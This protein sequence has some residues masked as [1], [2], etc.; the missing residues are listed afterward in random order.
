VIGFNLVPYI[1]GPFVV[2]ALFLLAASAAPWP[3]RIVAAIAA[4]MAA[5]LTIGAV[6]AVILVFDLRAPDRWAWVADAAD[7][8][9]RWLNVTTG[10]DDSTDWLRRTI[11]GE[12]AALDVFDGRADHEAALQRA[13]RRFPPDD[14]SVA[15]PRTIGGGRSSEQVD[16]AFLLMSAHEAHGPDRDDL[17]EA[18]A[19][20]LRPGGRLILVE[21]LRDLPN[22]LAF[23]PGAWHF[24]PRATW[25]ETAGRAGLRPVTEVGL[26]PFVRGFVFAT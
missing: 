26:T 1:L 11:G 24:Q 21:H 15:S 25:I 20:R 3:V 19:D 23:G 18:I 7:D 5:I 22:A 9:G 12:G 13:R 4:C 10:F 14:A 2:V 16:T 6:L 8:P 17:F